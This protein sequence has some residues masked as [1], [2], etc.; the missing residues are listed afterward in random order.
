[1]SRHNWPTATRTPAA[2]RAPANAMC[3]LHVHL[4][5][6]TSWSTFG[7]YGRP[8]MLADSLA[9]NAIFVLSGK[10]DEAATEA[11]PDGTGKPICKKVIILPMPVASQALNPH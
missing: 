6:S 4:F 1:M 11:D 3:M 7:K 10:H 5:G 9:M 8:V 2:T